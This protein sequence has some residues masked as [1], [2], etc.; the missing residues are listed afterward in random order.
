MN[1]DL[2]EK[3]KEMI[4]SRYP[5]VWVKVEDTEIECLGHIVIT[6]YLYG[7]EYYFKQGVDFRYIKEKDYQAYFIEQLFDSFE[8]EIRQKTFKHLNE[9]MKVEV[10]N[11]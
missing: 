9:I 1:M 2:F 4:Y 5:F 3:L 7:R 6:Y 8:S 10:D 11:E